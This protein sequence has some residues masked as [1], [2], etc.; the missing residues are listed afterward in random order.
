MKNNFDILI[1]LELLNTERTKLMIS[2]YKVENQIKQCQ[3]E[4]EK[5]LGCK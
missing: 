5:T 1:K 4:I 2:A 3:K